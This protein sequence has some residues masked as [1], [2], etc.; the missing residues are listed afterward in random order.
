V[1]EEARCENGSGHEQGQMQK[2]SAI[3]DA[4]PAETTL[5]CMFAG[6][7]PCPEQPQTVPPQRLLLLLL[8][9]PAACRR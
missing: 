8:L 5:V 1:S 3:V 2:P 6:V 7:L 9:V 4:R